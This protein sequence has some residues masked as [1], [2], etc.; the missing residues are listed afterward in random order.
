MED[1]K[2][3][4]T[5]WF[6]SAAQP[7]TIL[8]AASHPDRGF[9]GKYLAQYNP[10]WPLTHIGDFDMTRSAPPGV[11]EFYIGGYGGLSVV[12]TV[13]TGQLVIS[14]I[15]ERYRT[16]VNSTDVYA[17]AVGTS[18][19]PEEF[20]EYGAFAHW[21]GGTLKRAFSATRE[22]VF[23]DQGLPYAFESSFWAGN[24]PATGIQLP[25]IPAQL[26]RAAEKEWL[27]FSPADADLDVFI[28]AFATD[29]RPEVK[30]EIKP[31]RLTGRGNSR[32]QEIASS[33]S[34]QGYDDYSELRSSS[35]SE[36]PSNKQLAVDLAKAAG[37]A[38]GAGSK[39]LS[40]LAGKIG[41]EV[42]RRARNTDRPKQEK[43]PQPPTDA[44]E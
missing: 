2:T 14:E 30:A 28:S 22:T 35:R 32:S 26:A 18:D 13:F 16:L 37:S 41:D 3:L 29:G 6:V 11:D 15:P 38:I 10:S 42:R 33:S 4:V 39:K 36:E 34:E 12:Q 24:A 23:E 27:S 19:S 25:F 7:R 43:S 21:A 31:E 8:E 17:V 5:L 40:A 44:P 9:A 20:A 1:A